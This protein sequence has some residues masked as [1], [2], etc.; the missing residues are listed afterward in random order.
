MYTA[1]VPYDLFACRKRTFAW[2]AD[3]SKCPS[4]H[5]PAGFMCVALSSS[6]WDNTAS[7]FGLPVSMTHTT[8]DP[9]MR[10]ALCCFDRA[11][12]ANGLHDCAT[13]NSAGACM[14]AELPSGWLEKAPCEPCSWLHGGHGTGSRQQWCDLVK[15][16]GRVP[17]HH[18][19]RYC[20]LLVECTCLICVC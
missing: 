3:L 10:R 8:G 19:C 20:N 5:T 17:I 14:P 15:V 2:Q 4:H 16:Q 13:C 1:A 9:V 18:R 6:I 7:Y 12:V 11:S